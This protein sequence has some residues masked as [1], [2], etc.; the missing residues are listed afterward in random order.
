MFRALSFGRR[1]GTQGLALSRP[2]AHQS[3]SLFQPPVPNFKPEQGLEPLYSATALKEYMSGYQANLFEHLNRLVNETPYE[4]RK[5]E[6]LVRLRAKSP[7][8]VEI[9]EIASQ[10]WASKFFLEGLTSDASEPREEMML[11]MKESFGSFEQLKEQFTNEALGIF[12]SGWVWLIQ[13]PSSQYV[14]IVSTFNGDTPLAK[15][16][17]NMI[18]S[19]NQMA[20]SQEQVEGKKEEDG[21]QMGLSPLS[22]SKTIGQFNQDSRVAS[23]A[24]KESNGPA[25]ILL[26]MPVWEHAYFRDFG[27]LGREEY[28]RRFWDRVNWDRVYLRQ[29]QSSLI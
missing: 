7:E 26:C 27:V 21:N 5:L 3:R 4:K 8:E 14:Y 9:C 1:L 28:A 15:A 6:D 17:T 12:G 18:A 25:R 20:D 19:L 11:A 24:G 16:N 13:S 10:A 29:N 22:I 2:V 23:Q